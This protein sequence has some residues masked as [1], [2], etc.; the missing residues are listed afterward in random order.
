MTDVSNKDDILG[1]SVS[2]KYFIDKTFAD[3]VNIYRG[4]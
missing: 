1:P 2:N 4:L 3:K